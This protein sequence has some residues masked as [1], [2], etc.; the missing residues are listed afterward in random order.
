MNCKQITK[1]LVGLSCDPNP[2]GV[3][4]LILINFS[5]VATIDATAINYSDGTSGA[6]G[7]NGSS[8]IT[9]AT[10]STGGTVT[11]YE[12]TFRR[13]TASVSEN[14]T[15]DLDTGSSYYEQTLS[16]RLDKIERQKRDELMLVDNSQMMAIV[17]H[18]NGSYWLYGEGDGLQVTT[19]ESGTGTAKADP[20][21]Y[22]ITFVAQETYRA[23]EV[24]LAL[25]NTILNP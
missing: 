1:G 3:K 19:N 10:N 13:G 9:G 15:K 14:L 21:G 23:K 16:I 8:Y 11:G 25:V 22:T 18:S 17:Q 7:T 6:T 20:N 12:Y 24:A 5:D 4:S 2:G